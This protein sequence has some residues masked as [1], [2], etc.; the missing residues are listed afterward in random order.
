MILA[1]LPLRDDES[2]SVSFAGRTRRWWALWM[3][4]QRVIASN[5]GTFALPTLFK[6]AHHIAEQRGVGIGP[7]AGLDRSNTAIELAAIE[8]DL[9]HDWHLLIGFRTK[10]NGWVAW[11]TRER[12]HKLKT[13]SVHIQPTPIAAIA[14]FVADFSKRGAQ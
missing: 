4:R 8:R 7:K 13:I 3:D 11:A 1:S 2:I 9:P 6:L 14:A 10:D 12:G 5:D